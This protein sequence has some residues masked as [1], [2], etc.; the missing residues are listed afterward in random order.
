MVESAVTLNRPR[1]LEA[2]GAQQAHPFPNLAIERNHRLCREE[3]VFA[4]PASSGIGDVVP[5]EVVWPERRSGHA[6]GG[7]RYLGIDHY[8]PVGD[9]RSGTDKTQARVRLRH[10]DAEIRPG[11]L[12][13][14]KVVA[15]AA[16]IVDDVGAVT[17][18]IREEPY[19]AYP[20]NRPAHRVVEAI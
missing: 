5:H 18:E 13:R 3:A 19:S 17:E 16:Q 20:R 4:R 8:Q 11:L 14:R 12:D 7:A 2:R 6:E 10:L 9:H 15:E 1:N